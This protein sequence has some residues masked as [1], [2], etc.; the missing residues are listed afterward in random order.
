MH[1]AGMSHEGIKTSQFKIMKA[2]VE[3]SFKFRR[4]A[5]VMYKY[6]KTKEIIGDPRGPK[7]RFTKLTCSGHS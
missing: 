5:S 1:I 2:Y 7:L 6:H 3:Y 4:L